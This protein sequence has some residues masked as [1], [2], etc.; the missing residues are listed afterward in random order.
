MAQSNFL[1]EILMTITFGVT[2]RAI[3]SCWKW[4]IFSS[5]WRGSFTVFTPHKK[6]LAFIER[7]LLLECHCHKTDI[8]IITSKHS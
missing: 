2:Q 5:Q 8:E 3:Q 4:T 7:K 1:E 6:S